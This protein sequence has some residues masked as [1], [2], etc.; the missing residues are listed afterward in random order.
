MG[1]DFSEP[2][3]PSVPSLPLFS[4]I[5][6]LRA[7]GG[8]VAATTRSH[9]RQATADRTASRLRKPTKCR[10]IITTTN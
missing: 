1:T 7:A 6:E 4:L 9:Q 8:V 2:A 10:A 5:S 3:Y